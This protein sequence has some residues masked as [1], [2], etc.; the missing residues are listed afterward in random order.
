MDG[1]LAEAP[2][3]NGKEEGAVKMSGYLEKRG[4]FRLVATWKRYWFVLEGRLLL[5]YGS[6]QDYVRLS[7]CRGSINMGLVS[8]VR[9]G[10]ARGARLHDGYTIEV[11]TR[12]QRVVLRMKER[13]VQEQW[14]Q[15]LLDSIGC[16]QAAAPAA[17]G[18][19]HFRYSMD[20]LP[21][22]AKSEAGPEEERQSTLPRRARQQ[23][24][25]QHI[26]K[27]GGLEAVLKARN[28]RYG[29]ARQEGA[30]Q[31]TPG[32]HGAAALRNGTGE[33]VENRLY[34]PSGDRPETAGRYEVVEA[35]ADREGEVYYSSLDEERP[36][37]PQ[38]PELPPR[39]PA[40][41]VSAAEDDEDAD[42]AEYCMLGAAPASTGQ[43]ADPRPKARRRMSFIHRLMGK[44]H[45]KKSKHHNGVNHDTRRSVN[46]GVEYDVI[47]YNS[48]ER[49]AGK[50]NS[51]EEEPHEVSM[52]SMSGA[53]SL[54]PN[55]TFQELQK[56]LRDRT[57]PQP[58]PQ[59]P[60]EPDY[61]AEYAGFEDAP[62]RLPVPAPRRNLAQGSEPEQPAGLAT[63][64]G[65]PGA[66]GP[67]ELPPRRLV[68]PRSPWH[69]V[70]SNN[71]PIYGNCEE[72]F[73]DGPQGYAVV[74]SRWQAAEAGGAAQWTRER[75]QVTF[76][77]RLGQRAGPGD[78]S[79]PPGPALTLVLATVHSEDGG[80]GGENTTS[81]PRVAEG[82]KPAASPPAPALMK[83]NTYIDLISEGEH[84]AIN[85]D[86]ESS[87]CDD[88]SHTC[89]T[90]GEITLADIHDCSRK[91][92][93]RLQN[94]N[95]SALG[96][97]EVS[98]DMAPDSLMSDDASQ[99]SA[100]WD[101]SRWVA[102][103]G[104]SRDAPACPACSP[105]D[106]ARPLQCVLLPVAKRHSDEL[107]D[108]QEDVERVEL[109]RPTG[110]ALACPACSP[111][112]GARPLQCVL[113]PVAQRHS[114]EL[115]LLLAQLAEIT[116][117]PL[118]SPGVTISLVDFPEGRT[119]G[120]ELDEWA[121]VGPI[122]RRRH[123]DPDYDVPR[124]HRSL[125]LP[126]GDAGEAA[127]APRC[128]G[129][130]PPRPCAQDVRSGKDQVLEHACTPAS[131]ITP[132][133]L[134]LEQ[135]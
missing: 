121:A 85:L 76:P 29:S 7:A 56:R 66:G 59:D 28:N 79:P 123:S 95:D 52:A 128:L 119:H 110:D 57:G 129:R 30:A 32:Q 92:T 31:E 72:L 24:L 104:K 4:K 84:E 53:K 15:A 23:G 112:D 118:L 96:N 98:E 48:F 12:T 19:L 44:Y 45:K 1:S 58:S 108:V 54:M 80:C 38:E 114:D 13:P 33:V 93:D 100:S 10:A 107:N 124:P 18:S 117:A 113:L 47:D 101:M 126:G 22:A 116:S 43:R 81:V 130:P 99:C 35:P 71:S 20:A 73:S 122:R 127:Q 88:E 65:Q 97:E 102:E 78:A 11:V 133:S 77:S 74:R 115:N 37:E 61:E 46:D 120:S 70:P 135:S 34:D 3:E 49:D 14:L 103:E 36:Q 105:G 63:E 90:V 25:L 134:E 40:G 8:C 62:R 109:R 27:M 41:S 67:P 2:Q 125:L 83:T 87:E 51:G 64:G 39:P 132:D 94:T 16:Q 60:E 6:E 42:Y 131:S 91:V 68:R 50:G 82:T 26:K 69:D 111:G 5:Y 89:I 55:N 21:T 75:R 106:G 9:P 17:G 86:E